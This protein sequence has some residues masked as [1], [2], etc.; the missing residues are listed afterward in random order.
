M[1]ERYDFLEGASR[2]V[3]GASGNGRRLEFAKNS[4]KRLEAGHVCRILRQLF[5]GGPCRRQI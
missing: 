1:V 4:N 2:F 5:R 3:T